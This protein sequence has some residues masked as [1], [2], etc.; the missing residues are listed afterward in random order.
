M[1]GTRF[2]GNTARATSE[3]A[4]AVGEGGAITASGSTLVMDLTSSEVLDSTVIT[5]GARSVTFGGGVSVHG[6]LTV[7]GSIV[8]GNHVTARAGSATG[9]AVGGGIAAE[10]NA[11]LALRRST[12][13]ANVADATSEGSVGDAQGGGIEAEQG[14]VVDVRSSTIDANVALAASGNASPSALGGGLDLETDAASD[15]ILNSTI[16]RNAATATGPNA[17]AAGG[18]VEVADGSF[19]VQL[20]TIARNGVTASGT[21]SFAGGGGLDVE[22]GTTRLEGVIVAINQAVTGQTCIGSITTDGFNVFGPTAGC[23]VTP[24]ATDQANVAKPELGALHGNGGPTQTLALLADSP[25]VNRIPAAACHDMATRD[26]R[27]TPR[28]Q[29]TKCDVGAFE[30]K[31]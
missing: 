6:T 25:A 14:G 13:E 7:D 26:Q 11:V 27:G 2:E 28:P 30:R 12:I 9:T 23:T 20:A 18:A 29:G 3:I 17:I 8:A 31:I 5:R 19:V 24:V 10:N 1:T 22:E 21:N 15:R 4:T 16:T